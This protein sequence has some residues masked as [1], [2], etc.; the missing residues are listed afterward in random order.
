MGTDFGIS[1]ASARTSGN[2]KRTVGLNSLVPQVLLFTVR[3][4]LV[5]VRNSATL[6]KLS[7]RYT[8]PGANKSALI[9][10]PFAVHGACN[11]P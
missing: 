9:G 2:L 4:A 10:W 7:H 3:A 5:M 1:K 11:G 8:R 6:G